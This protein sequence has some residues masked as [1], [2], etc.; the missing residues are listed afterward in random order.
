LWLSQAPTRPSSDLYQPTRENLKTLSI[1]LVQK[2]G[3]VCHADSAYPERDIE[4]VEGMFMH[5]GRLDLEP[6][7]IPHIQVVVLK[8]FSCILARIPWRMALW[9]GRYPTKA[10]HGR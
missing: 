2:L 1:N 7:Q 4:L 3:L 6:N 8:D 5:G 9:Y 10:E